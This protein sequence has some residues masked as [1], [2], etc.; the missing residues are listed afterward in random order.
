MIKR[1]CDFIKEEPPGKFG[2]HSHYGIE[3]ITFLIRHVT[4]QDKVIKG[5][6]D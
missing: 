6:S 5:S 2:R 3:D 1:F 4:V